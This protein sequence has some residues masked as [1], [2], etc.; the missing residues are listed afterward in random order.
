VFLISEHVNVDMGLIVISRLFDVTITPNHG[1]SI[2][3][4]T[5]PLYHAR[6]VLL[7]QGIICVLFEMGHAPHI[8]AATI[9]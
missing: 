2:C 7:G 8:L 6:V 3:R 9:L 4:I 1:S 5:T